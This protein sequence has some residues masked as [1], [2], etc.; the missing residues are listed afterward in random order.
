MYTKT[1]CDKSTKEATL[2]I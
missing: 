1:S 2:K